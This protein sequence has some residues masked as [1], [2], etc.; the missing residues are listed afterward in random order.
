MRQLA[1]YLIPFGLLLLGC[2]GGGGSSPF[3]PAAPT[4][5]ALTD[6]LADPLSESV[7]VALADGRALLIGGPAARTRMR[8][9]DP[10]TDLWSDGP[11]LNDARSVGHSAT[12]LADGR[13]LVIGGFSGGALT[14]AEVF[15][16]AT[17]MVS[18]TVGTSSVPRAFHVAALLPDG[19]VLVAGGTDATFPNVGTTVTEIWD[20]ATGL[21]TLTDPLAT[22]RAVSG[23]ATL[24]TGEILVIGGDDSGIFI[25]SCE[26]FDPVLEA[27]S[28]TGA[29]TRARAYLQGLVARAGDGRIL[30]TGGST[31]AAEIY[32]PATGMWSLHLGM[33]Q[34][35]RNG[36][37]ALTLRDG[38]VLIAGGSIPGNTVTAEAEVFDPLTDLFTAIAP[39]NVTRVRMGAALLGDDRV[40]VAGG[41][42][43]LGPVVDTETCEAYTP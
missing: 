6:P 12:R 18:L 22:G 35:S 11:T 25:G 30:V 28:A 3:V 41:T 13:V 36:G 39:M 42:M 8:I 24:A 7:A 20:P 1:A 19:R 26:L 37:L 10:A 23:V 9:F 32:D 43:S 34:A 40:L 16:P 14:S 15:D 31:S 4:A 5:W 21:F 38:R 27:W 17:N 29:L 33:A 2:G